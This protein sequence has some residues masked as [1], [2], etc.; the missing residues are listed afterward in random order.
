MLLLPPPPP[1]VGSV[2]IAPLT[3]PPPTA[4]FNTWPAVTARV[5]VPEA[6]LP[7][8]G[9]NP[10]PPPPPMTVTVIEFIPAG[11]VQTAAAV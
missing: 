8:A 9:K 6:A 4:R 1:P 11:T 2:S 7:P 5:P 3:P 10:E